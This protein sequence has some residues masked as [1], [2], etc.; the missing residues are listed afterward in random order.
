MSSAAYELRDNHTEFAAALLAAFKE[1][2]FPGSILTATV[3]SCYRT[4]HA[5]PRRSAEDLAYTQGR[6]GISAEKFLC[7]KSKQVD[8]AITT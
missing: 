5:A 3:H 8:N 2:G 6:S 1:L 7:M 4:L